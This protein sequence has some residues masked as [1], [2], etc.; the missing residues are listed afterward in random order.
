MEP[1]ALQRHATAS[2]DTARDISGS[3]PHT[4][5][6]SALRR[7]EAEAP[8]QGRHRHRRRQG[9]GNRRGHRDRRPPVL[10]PAL[11]KWLDATDLQPGQWLRTSAGTYVQITAI[12]HWTSLGATVHNLTVGDTHTYYVAA[13]ASLLLV[14][15]DN[16][17]IS[18]ETREHVLDGVITEKGRLA[19]P[20]GPDQRH[21]QQPLHQR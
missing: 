6:L 3:R 16:C 7:I 11:G 4:V 13:G 9:R 5:A 17:P 18:A 14:H 10:G 19:S 21:S 1:D 15:D 20:P 12:E 8:G 2:P